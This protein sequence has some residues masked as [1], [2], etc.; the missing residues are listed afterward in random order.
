M[1]E[2]GL[3]EIRRAQQDGRWDA[4]Y[5]SQR[6]A[7]PPPELLARLAADTV[8]EQAFAALDRTARYQ[9]ILPLLR[10]RTPAA[11]AAAL[12]RALR[13]LSGR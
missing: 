3:A 2:P 11:R 13:A 1:R 9:L 5:A 7:E 10:A 12:D 8:A 4:A 6:T